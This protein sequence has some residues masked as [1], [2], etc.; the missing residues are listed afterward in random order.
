MNANDRLHDI[1]EQLKRA[2]LSYET[3]VVV[4]TCN[5]IVKQID[6]VL[7][8]EGFTGP[9]YAKPCDSQSDFDD[10]IR[11][12]REEEAAKAGKTMD[13]V[14]QWREAAAQKT[15]DEFWAEQLAGKKMHPCVP[16]VQNLVF[17]F[18]LHT[19]IGEVE[20]TLI[21]VYATRL[22]DF[23]LLH[24]FQLTPGSSR[25]LKDIPEE[26]WN[27]AL[28]RLESLPVGEAIALMDFEVSSA[29][30]KA[31]EAYWAAK[32][33][34]DLAAGLPTAQEYREF[35]NRASKVVNNITATGVNPAEAGAMAKKF[36]LRHGTVEDLKQITSNQWAAALTRLEELDGTAAW[37]AINEQCFNEAE[38][39]RI[40]NGKKAANAIREQG[41]VIVEPT[42]DMPKDG[43]AFL[44]TPN[45]PV[46]V[47]KA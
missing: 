44:L 24:D 15:A 34:A 47:A 21:K 23:I 40:V 4:T 28:A 11:E 26:S 37:S 12:I 38:Y 33:A 43:D 32:N 16:R 7:Q 9:S 27:A 6:N 20:K 39:D 45:G 42:A 14:Q 31:Q 3:E 10:L 30:K 13:A 19:A 22:Q 8:L 18:A 41:G 25:R 46:K 1:R 2:L 36:V 5:D 35:V 29:E 17:K